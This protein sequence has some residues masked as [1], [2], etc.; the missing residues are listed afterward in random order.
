MIG[1][2]KTKR[3]ALTLIIFIVVGSAAGT[4]YYLT[5][6]QPQNAAPTLT[7]SVLP[8][9]TPKT[10]IITSTPSSTPNQTVSPTIT[11]A[12]TPTPAPTVS[13]SPTITPTPTVSSTPN[14]APWIITNINQATTRENLT[15]GPGASIVFSYSIENKDNIFLLASFELKTNIEWGILDAKSILLVV[16]GV[17]EFLPS[18]W[19]YPPRDR[20]YVGDF[21]GNITSQGAAL[22]IVD[23]GSPGSTGNRT[24]SMTAPEQ[25]TNIAFVYI[26]SRSYLDGTHLFELKIAGLEKGVE[27]NIKLP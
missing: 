25:T 4:Y 1:S 9:S 19:A 2:M 11:P 10:P 16:D 14:P 7:P 23:Y 27:F 21:S 13:A 8:T 24:V 20:G 12:L 3:F 22:Q 6:M 15:E 5:T 18:G 17:N 26:V